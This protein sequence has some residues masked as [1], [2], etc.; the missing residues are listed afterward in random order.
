MS[1]AEGRKKLMP[2]IKAAE[3]DTDPYFLVHF[4]RE[5]D[6]YEGYHEGMDEFDA[7]IV[8]KHLMEEFNLLN[9]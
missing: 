1:I 7:R 9:P 8:I 4:S 2:F 3:K 6:R 5:N